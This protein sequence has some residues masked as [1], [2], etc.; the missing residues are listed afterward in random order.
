MSLHDMND[1][2]RSSLELAKELR[3]GDGL[4]HKL[5]YSKKDGDTILDSLS[6]TSKSLKDITDGV[7][8]WLRRTACLSLRG[9]RGRELLSLTE[10]AEIG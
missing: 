7:R 3:D 4:L 5:V 2:F 1:A 10:L 9:P 6:E 8:K